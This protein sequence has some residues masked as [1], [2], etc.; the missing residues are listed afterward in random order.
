[1]KEKCNSSCHER[2]EIEICTCVYGE[3]RQTVGGASEK[4]TD[5]L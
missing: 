3:K 5:I 4:N 1:M 2:A